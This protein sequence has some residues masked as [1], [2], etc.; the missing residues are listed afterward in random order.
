MN[1]Y[2]EYNAAKYHSMKYNTVKIKYDG[3]LIRSDYNV[4]ENISLIFQP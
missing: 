4:K 2:H 3:N 1:L